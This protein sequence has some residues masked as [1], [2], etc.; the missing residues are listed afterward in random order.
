[1]GQ[2]KHQIVKVQLT[3]EAFDE[4]A[5]YFGILVPIIQSPY[6]IEF[7]LNWANLPWSPDIASLNGKM[8]AKLGKGA[9]AQMGGGRAG[10]ILRLVSFDALLRKL[11]F[12]FSD[13]FSDDFDFDS[14]KGDATLKNG[15]MT[16]KNTE[17]DGLVADIAFNGEVDLVKRQINVEA[18][19]TPEISATVGVATA[20]V[21]NPFAGA[22]VFAATKVLGPLWS[23]VSVIRY[24]VTG[25]LDEPKID[26]V[27]RQLKETQE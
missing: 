8:S 15:V 27:L 19:I 21:V 14:I 3:G 7:D 16:S 22:A 24:R 18:V 5:A 26:E 20:F 17:V 9:I 12:D 25:S 10:Q 13:T 6:T 23:K 1:N 11:R 4:T 2:I